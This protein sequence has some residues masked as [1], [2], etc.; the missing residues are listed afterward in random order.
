MSA[1]SRRQLEL[2]TEEKTLSK[3]NAADAAQAN[4]RLNK[5]LDDA[6]AQGLVKP[7]DR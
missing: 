5:L 7:V 4:Q 2:S 1:L 6:V 3:Q